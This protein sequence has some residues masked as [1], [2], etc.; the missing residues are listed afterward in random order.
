MDLGNCISVGPLS[1]CFSCLYQI[2]RALR[3]IVD[4]GMHHQKMKRDDAIKM[5]AD[6]AWDESD[7]TKKEVRRL[8]C[9]IRE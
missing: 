1:S 7:F 4:T 6:Y 5:F 8:L 3:L 9:N 2:W